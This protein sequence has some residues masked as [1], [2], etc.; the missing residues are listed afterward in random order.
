[1]ARIVHILHI[2]PREMEII[3]FVAS[4]ESAKQIGLRLNIAPSTVERH[5]ENVRLK[6]ATKNRPE[7]I[8]HLFRSGH[9][10]H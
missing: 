3:N 9:L 10:A 2:T 4:G 7:L 6:T 8:A 1:M 5:I